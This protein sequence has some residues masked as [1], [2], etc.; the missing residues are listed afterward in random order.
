MKI[1]LDDLCKQGG[2]AV[3][4]S[5]IASQENLLAILFRCGCGSSINSKRVY[6]V[7]LTVVKGG[8]SGKGF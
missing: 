6:R 1:S 3:H 4:H 7:N 2:I 5:H 8:A